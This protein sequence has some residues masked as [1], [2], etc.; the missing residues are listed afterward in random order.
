MLTALKLGHLNV[1]SLMPSFLDFKTYL[2]GDDYSIFCLSETW[3]HEGVDDSYLNIDNYTFLR[4]D[5]GTRGGGVGIYIKNDLSF[6]LF[7]YDSTI[8]QLWVFIHLNHKVFAVGVIYRP[9]WCAYGGFVDE[10]ENALSEI[11][12]QCD[13]V[14]LMGD[15]NI[16][17][18]FQDNLP[19]TV[20][21]DAM[22]SFNLEQI[23]DSPTCFSGT[24]PSTIDLI[25]VSDRALVLDSGVRDISISNHA[26]IFCHLNVK[27][28]KPNVVSHTYRSTKFFDYSLFYSDLLS[29]PFYLIYGLT[30]VND[31]ALFLTN[32]LTELLNKHMPLV[33]SKFTRAPAPWLTDTIRAMQSLRDRA[34]RLY[35]QNRSPARWD[36]YKS[37]RNLTNGAIRREKRA[38]MDYKIRTA[39]QNSKK[40]WKLL[41]NTGIVNKPSTSIP[42]ELG[43]PE[44]INL[45]F[46]NSV[47]NLQLDEAVCDAYFYTRSNNCD[48]EF[49]AVTDDVVFNIIRS[50]KSNAA[51]VDG[52][53]V[54]FIALCCPHILP[55]VTFIIN[56]CLL[57]GQFPDCW[58]R[59]LVLPLPKKSTVGQLGDLRPIS[60]VPIISKIAERVIEV[61]LKD[62]IIQCDILPEVQSG[63][64]KNYSCNTALLN[65]TDD[66]VGSSDEGSLTVMCLL[67]YSKAF[68]TI[69]HKLLSAILYHI[70]LG[71]TAVNLVFNYITGR[72]QC[73]SVDGCVS[74][75]LPIVRGVPQG[76]VLGP[77][78]YSI[79]T[80]QFA[81]CLQ[82]AKCHFYADDTQ[83]YYSF[84]PHKV[85]EACDRLNQDLERLCT[86]SRKHSLCIN[87]SKTEV[88]VFG[89]KKFRLNPDVRNCI[90]IFVDGVQIELKRSVKN[91]GIILNDELDFTEY[92]NLCT[93]RSYAALKAIYSNRMFLDR[94]TKQLLCESLVL[95]RLNYCDSLYG[96]YISAY[97]ARRL[98]KIQNSCLRLIFGIRRRQHISHKLGDVKWLNMRNRRL[99][100]SATL[101][102]NIISTGKPPY[103]Y[104]RIRFRTDV[105]HV[106][107][108]YKGTLTPPLHRLEHFK[109]SFSYQI[110]NVYNNLPTHVKLAPSIFL[111]KRRLFS[112]LFTKQQTGG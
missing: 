32:H 98:Q 72:M 37:L 79:Y 29:T 64:R 55:Y 105:H 31:M 3:L 84:P 30:D 4:R 43:G 58:K 104:R 19:A 97:N 100:H 57:N 76:S 70:G 16:N 92:M 17:I 51:G 87:P 11:V 80:C 46:V 69:N 23:I 5:R 14:V 33:T 109:R 61:Q 38:Y 74:S 83:L 112:F 89:P 25:F 27:Y 68:D 110:T 90:K 40:I 7:Q 8:E 39:G 88:I 91:L 63:F 21:S 2:L 95:S 41:K 62:F 75:F 99:L 48:F 50:I 49:S 24:N 86:I 54:N 73:V 35:K 56:F 85:T 52:L 107:I 18:Q 26:L 106:N 96:S 47:P 111:F 71:S 65:I 108:R 53:N 20:L 36:Y 59:S 77:L 42:P 1:C 34:F 6:K 45:F 12:P 66:I 78:L 103:L 44:S 22:T 93:Q 10:L 28:I 67:D 82:F 13:T 9:P 102:H 94:K 81:K 60:I 15:F 101:F